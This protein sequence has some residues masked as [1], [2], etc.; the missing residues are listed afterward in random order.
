M[1]FN[2]VMIG[3]TF[4]SLAMLWGS[5][6]YGGQPYHTLY[7]LWLVSS[8]IGFVVHVVTSC[9]LI[10]RGNKKTMIG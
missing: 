8:M 2:G 7:S 6:V 4:S 10:A 1:G 5:L 9:I 3:L